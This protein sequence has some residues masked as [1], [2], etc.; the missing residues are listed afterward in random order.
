[1]KLSDDN[2]DLVIIIALLLAIGCGLYFSKAQATEPE[3]G[4]NLII[5]CDQGIPL[6]LEAYRDKR[7]EQ[8][9][10]L[11]M[12]QSG[13]KWFAR[14]DAQPDS[15]RLWFYEQIATFVDQHD[16]KTTV[17]KTCERKASL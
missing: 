14:I 16:E 15:E 10:I 13:K 9:D 7:I 12:W 11:E 8:Y 5:S 2:F 6:Y 4:I 17:I 3:R 1:M